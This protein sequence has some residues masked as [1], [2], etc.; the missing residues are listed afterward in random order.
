MGNEKMVRIK[1]HADIDRL[2]K[3]GDWIDLRIAEDVEMKAGEFK[4]FSLGVSMEI[5]TGFEALVIPRSSTFMKY[6]V[7]L[8]NSLGLIDESYNGDND[9]WRFPAYAT[10]DTFIPKNTRVC[11]FRII[12][13][14]P[15]IV[16]DEVDTL[17]NKDRGGFGSTGRI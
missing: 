7:I 12:E 8:S 14:Q 1:Y 11:Q 10:R 3:H 13:H 15:E 9:I 6:G 2:E 4:M 16:F 17:G 5:P